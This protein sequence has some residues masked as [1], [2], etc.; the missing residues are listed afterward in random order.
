MSLH[1]D[2]GAPGC[3]AK[4]PNCLPAITRR[5]LFGEVMSGMMTE[6]LEFIGEHEWIVPIFLFRNQEDVRQYIYTLSRDPSRT[7]EV[8]GRKGDDFIGIVIDDEGKV[9]RFIAGEAKWRKTWNDSTLDRVMLGDKI[10]DPKDPT[11]SLHNGKGVWFEINRSL[12]V[13]MV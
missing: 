8:Y 7:R 5:G 9:T 1:P 4:Y 12:K 10:K 6:A 11:K 3:N 13:P 2:A